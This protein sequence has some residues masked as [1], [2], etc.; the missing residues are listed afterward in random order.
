MASTNPVTASGNHRLK[1]KL[2]T[3]RLQEQGMELEET[4]TETGANRIRPLFLKAAD[5]MSIACGIFASTACSL[6]AT[7][8]FIDCG[9]EFIGNEE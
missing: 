9:N 2:F 8:F 4:L 1:P 7:Y 3:E 5:A 6:L